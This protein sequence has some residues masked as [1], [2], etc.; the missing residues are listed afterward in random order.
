MIKKRIA[1]GRLLK[2][3]FYKRKGILTSGAR[4]ALQ[5]IARIETLKEN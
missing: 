3:C 5:F 4:I 1:L 2:I